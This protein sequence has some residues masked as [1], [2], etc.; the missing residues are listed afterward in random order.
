MKTIELCEA[1]DSL[2]EYAE[3]VEKDAVLV[4][5]N[6]KPVAVLSSVKGMDAESI[7]LANNPKFV[8]IIERSRASYAKHGGISVN[9]VRR[10]LGIP[11][12]KP[13]K[14]SAI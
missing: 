1:K 7:A 2:R 6:G 8:A 11:R 5:K 13:R 14:K 9:E 12:T 10:R 3:Q 4:V